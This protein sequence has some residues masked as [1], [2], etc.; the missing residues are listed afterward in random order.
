MS[1]TPPAFSGQGEHFNPLHVLFIKVNSHFHH[2]GLWRWLGEKKGQGGTL[3]AWRGQGGVEKGVLAGAGNG[4]TW[5]AGSFSLNSLLCQGFRFLSPPSLPS[6]RAL[7]V[8]LQPLV[9]PASLSHWS[10]PALMPDSTPSPWSRDPTT[11][12]RGVLQFKQASLASQSPCWFLSQSLWTQGSPSV[13]LP[14]L[15]AL[16][17]FLAVT[18]TA[19]FYHVKKVATFFSWSAASLGTSFLNRAMSWSRVC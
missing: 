12:L 5:A 7:P 18:L 3:V 6:Q 8:P 17:L 16:T 14:S 10:P 11:L 13:L 15:S 2:R 1:Q 4:F 19:A 9:S